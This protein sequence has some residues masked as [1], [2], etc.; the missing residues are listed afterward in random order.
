MNA[1]GYEY[2]AWM[3]MTYINWIIEQQPEDFQ[4]VGFIGT[5]YKY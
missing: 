1:M 3:F 2:T 5:P 4:Q